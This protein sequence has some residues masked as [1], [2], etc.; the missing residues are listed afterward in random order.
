MKYSYKQEKATIIKM[1]KRHKH[2]NISQMR[3][4]EQPEI[5]CK[6]AQPNWQENVKEI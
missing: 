4:S 1:G 6:D 3:K 5:T 2:F